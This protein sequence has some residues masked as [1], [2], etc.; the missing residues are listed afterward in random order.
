MKKSK[1]WIIIPIVLII[2]IVTYLLLTL[3]YF[4]I[5]NIKFFNNKIITKNEVGNYSRYALGQ[6]IFKFDKK[7]LKKEME[8]DIYIRSVKIDK[9]LPSTLAISI[10]ETKDICYFEF[11]NDKFF[12]DT[13]FNVVKNKDRVDF[14][15]ITKVVGANKNLKNL[16][17]LKSDEKFHEFLKE[18]CDH[19]VLDLISEIDVDN[20]DDI[21]LKTRNSI[22]IKYGNLSGFSDKSNKISK[23]LKEISTKSIKVKTIDI[24]DVNRPY[25]VK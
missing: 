19:K 1:L 24:S 18:L 4:S 20:N 21:V 25:L 16:N 2:G 9:K 15:K 12:V 11:G 17:N 10:E 8:K 7:H 14:T 23:I 5:K 13:D 22:I 6:N 3:E